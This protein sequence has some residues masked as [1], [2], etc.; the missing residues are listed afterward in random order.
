MK[1]L[2]KDI[3]NYDD[4]YLIDNDYECIYMQS[5]KEV[6]AYLEQ[7]KYVNVKIYKLVGVWK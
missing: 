2:N 7:S 4:K 1:D 3:S 5:A 6:I